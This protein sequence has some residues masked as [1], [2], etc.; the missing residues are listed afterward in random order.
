MEEDE[1]RGSTE[2]ALVLETFAVG[3]FACNCSIV[4]DRLSGDTVLIDPGAD[5][6]VIRARIEALG[7]RVS[8][9]IHTHTHVDHVGATAALSRACQVMPQIHEHDRF[10]YDM[11]P[12]QA[13]LVGGAAPEACEVA[14]NLLDESTVTAGRIELGV[15]HT[16]GH[17]PG[18]VSFLLRSMAGGPAIV[19]TGD[20]LFRGSIG[21][22]DLPGGDSDLILASL[23]ERLMTLDDDTEVVPG[24]GPASTIAIE[25][26][27][28]PFVR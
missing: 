21:R 6:H 23:R 15:I 4:F 14:G 22:T 12:I 26:R 25:R 28:N 11:L 2:D 18:S 3:P 19:F 17:T 9:I 16:P 24:H 1:G 27:I 7:A 20:T 5:E 8:A 10:L 13:A